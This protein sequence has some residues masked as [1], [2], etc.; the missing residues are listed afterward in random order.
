VPDQDGGFSGR[1]LVSFET[2]EDAAFA[3]ESAHRMKMDQHQLEITMALVPRLETPK[4]TLVV[5]NLVDTESETQRELWE[6]LSK[7]GVV[8]RISKGASL[9]FCCTRPVIFHVL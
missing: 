4:S 3:Q 8:L 1:A 6:A 9:P 7:F 5:D 2:P